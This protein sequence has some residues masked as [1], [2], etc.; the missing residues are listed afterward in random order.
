MAGQRHDQLR[1][2]P[3]PCQP[4]ELAADRLDLRR[5][6]QAQHPGPRHRRDPGGALSPRLAEQRQEHQHD[7]HHLQP[8]KAVPDPAVGGP[9]ALQQPGA[10]QRGQRQ[11]QPGQRIT[12]TGREHRGGTLAQQPE[13]GQHPLAV[14]RHRVRQHRQRLLLPARGLLPGRSRISSQPT[15]SALSGTIA[16]GRAQY[17]TD[18]R[19][20]HPGGGGDAGLA[21]ACPSSSGIRATTPGVSFEARRGPLRSGTRPARP[22]AASAFSHRHTLTGITPNASATRAWVAAISFHSCTAASRRARPHPPHPTR[23]W[24]ARAPTSPRCRPG[25]SPCP[26]P[27]RSPPR[28]PP[29]VAIWRSVRT[30]GET[31]TGTSPSP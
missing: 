12:G 18:R 10:R 4:G 1:G 2:L 11:Q 31:G 5:P 24:P 27:G 22:P 25:R 17:I 23:T 15:G 3:G 26:R 29:H 6:V 30:H 19:F 7:Q 16:P 8:V 13:P 20:R 28:P 21:Q 14:P 9:G